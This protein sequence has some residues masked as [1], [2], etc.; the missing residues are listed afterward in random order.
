MSDAL[1]GESPWK[2]P[3]SCRFDKGSPANFL[4]ARS[5]CRHVPRATSGT[6]VP[7][8]FPG[9]ARDLLLLLGRKDTHPAA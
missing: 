4:Y 7:K 8:Q 6:R 2:W 5:M 3:H 9:M 1:P